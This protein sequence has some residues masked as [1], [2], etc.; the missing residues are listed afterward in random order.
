ML[1]M[2]RKTV[3]IIQ[4]QMA[5][6]RIPF[7]DRLRSVLSGDEVDLNVAYGDYDGR[8]SASGYDK[9]LTSNLSWG[10]PFP[11]IH[12]PFGLIWHP[13]ISTVRGSDLIIAQHAARLSTNYLLAALKPFHA[14]R[15][16]FWGHGWNHQAATSSS[17]AE[18]V[19]T[20]VGKRAD[21]Y[22][23]YTESVRSGLIERG[24]DGAR[25]TAVQN[26]VETPAPPTKEDMASM[27]QEFGLDSACHKMALCCGT[28]T[29][30]RQLDDLIAAAGM[31]A[32][33]IPEF[34]LVIAGSGDEQHKAARAAQENPNIK[35]AGRALG[36]RKCALYEASQFAV[37][38]GLVGLGI[39]DAFHH[40]L[41]PLV[42]D[43]P[44]HSPEISYLE[45]GKNGMIVDQGAAG[46][47]DGMRRM[48][49]DSSL[50]ERLA[51]GS[52]ATGTK[53]T[54]NQMVA[55]FTEGILSS[56]QLPPRLI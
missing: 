51:H 22:F 7:F 45:D 38:P 44:Y 9:I 14:Y 27:W 19:N 8:P 39:V 46:L 33:D 13:V 1:G 40:G 24:Y 16:A 21:W 56:L 20:T 18:R 52:R 35:F 15:L 3:S 4:N 26:A 43:Y 2:P 47:A 48:L 17:M 23:A 42:T 36:A 41:P 12:L 32:K 29:A 10:T 5:H 28:L 11:R 37:L 54:M 55:N 34:V 53:I 25:I 30:R 49:R 50:R 31:V 6:Y